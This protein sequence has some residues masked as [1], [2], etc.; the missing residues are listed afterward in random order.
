MME[1]AKSARGGP[2]SRTYTTH[3]HSR[4]LAVAQDTRTRDTH[5]TR[6]RTH[7]SNHLNEVAFVLVEHVVVEVD[8]VCGDA[9][10]EATHKHAHTHTHKHTRTHTGRLQFDNWLWTVGGSAS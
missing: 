9:V 4:T 3:T 8:D 2:H 6:I 5:N 7:T 1:R 10:E